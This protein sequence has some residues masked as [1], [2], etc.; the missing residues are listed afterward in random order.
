[1][2]FRFKPHGKGK[3]NW[4]SRYH[5]LDH[6]CWTHGFNLE[7]YRPKNNLI[8][9]DVLDFIDFVYRL[10]NSLFLLVSW[11]TFPYDDSEFQFNIDDY[12]WTTW[13]LWMWQ[14]TSAWVQPI[15]YLKQNSVNVILIREKTLKLSNS[16]ENF[17]RFS[18]LY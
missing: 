14:K 9:F 12:K 4:F 11:M 1:M 5:R 18:G 10:R 16:F 7:G 3:Y 13:P 17:N 6:C 8:S 15:S 2:W